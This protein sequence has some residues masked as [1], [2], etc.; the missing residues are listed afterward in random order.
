VKAV[1]SWSIE[2]AKKNGES[3]K[4]DREGSGEGLYQILR[5]ATDEDRAF[6][7]AR[8]EKLEAARMEEDLRLEELK[9]R[10]LELVSRLPNNIRTNGKV[11][12]T[13]II[14]QFEGI[15]FEQLEKIVEALQTAP[16]LAGQFRIESE[17]A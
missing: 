9:Q 12:Q 10:V 8:E 2:V 7:A 14:M 13:R 17:A 16:A 4:F 15:T 1:T 5:I 6:S 11:Y 3:Q